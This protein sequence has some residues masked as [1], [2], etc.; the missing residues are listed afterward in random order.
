MLE[1]W[2]QIKEYE[3]YEISNLGRVR[4]KRRRLINKNGEYQT[5]P[6]KYLKIHKK[7]ITPYF[8]IS[9]DFWK[10]KKQISLIEC[11]AETF[12]DCDKENDIAYTYQINKTN[13]TLDDILIEKNSRVGVL[14]KYL[15]AGYIEV[16]K[17]Y[18]L[19]TKG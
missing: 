11:L 1:E 6:E 5:H 10:S 4:V 2:K 7:G 12:L 15:G 9:K 16:E 17:G 13:L 8:Y 19:N 18:F 3:N 14:Y